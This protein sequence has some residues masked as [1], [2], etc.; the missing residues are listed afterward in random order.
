[1]NNLRSYTEREII[2]MI[3]EGKVKAADLTDSGIC[4]TCFDKE[5]N[6]VLYGD[7]KNMIIYEDDLFECF[8]A[9]NPRANG[10]TII[11]TKKHYKDMMEADDETCQK[12]FMLAKKAMNVLK[13]VYQAESVYLC[14]MCDGPMNHFHVQLIPRYSFEERGSKNFVKERFKYQV[15]LEKLYYLRKRMKDEIQTY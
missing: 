7:N 12:I 9:G 3:K 4:P 11:S 15:D 5:H 14:T 1:M 8:L 6:H 10:H 13:E 2:K